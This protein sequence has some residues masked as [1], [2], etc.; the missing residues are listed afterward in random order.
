MPHQPT[1]LAA[2][3][4]TSDNFVFATAAAF[5]MVQMVGHTI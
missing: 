4:S 2:H 1:A 5:C 3:A